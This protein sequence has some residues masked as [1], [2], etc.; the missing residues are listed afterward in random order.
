MTSVW[1]GEIRT[2]AR[3]ELPDG[4]LP[5]DGRELRIDDHQ[6]LFSLFGWR[7]GGDHLGTFCLPTLAPHD[8]TP[9][10]RLVRGVAQDGLY[11]RGDNPMLHDSPVGEIRF[12]SG[13]QPPVGWVPCDGRML[14]I[15]APYLA[16]FEVIGHRWGGDVATFGVPNLWDVPADQAAGSVGQFS[17][18]VAVAPQASCTAAAHDGALPP[19]P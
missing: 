10:A 15:E 4:W 7:F 1:I 8:A 9:V 13:R 16:L 3:G 11:P 2:F 14:P 12:F 6:P 17:Y 5:C 19:H 18:L